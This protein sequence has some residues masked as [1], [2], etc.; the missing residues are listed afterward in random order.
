MTAELSTAEPFTETKAPLLTRRVQ[1][2]ASKA[3]TPLNVPSTTK[4]VAAALTRPSNCVPT[5]GVMLSMANPHHRPLRE[6]QFSRVKHVRC[7]MDRL[8]SVCWGD[9][10]DGLGTCV[11]GECEMTKKGGHAIGSACIQSDYRRSQYVSLNWAKWPFIIDALQ[12]ARVILWIE[13]DV[14]INRNPW[15]G[16]AGVPGVD[17]PWLVRHDKRAP[18]D[19]AFQWETVPCDPATGFPTPDNSTTWVKDPGVVCQSKSRHYHA[20]PLNCGQLLITSRRFAQAV[21]NSRP[22]QFQNGA[23]SQ[24]HHANVIKANFSHDGLPLDFFNYCWGLSRIVF[25][26]G[27]RWSPSTRRAPRTRS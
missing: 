14:V 25:A 4:A 24:Q 17:A 1:T 26:T 21:W 18:L 27:A 2:Y 9:W 20:E 13:A 8:I 7:L 12:V 5:G 19:V 16:L 15:E 6:M 10:D 22:V 23:P 3:R 11:R